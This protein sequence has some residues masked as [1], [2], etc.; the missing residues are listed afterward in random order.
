MYYTW[1][2]EIKSL[3][4]RT[5]TPFCYLFFLLNTSAPDIA[6]IPIRTRYNAIELL[7]LVSGTLSFA[8]EAGAFGFGIVFL[9]CCQFSLYF[10]IVT[11]LKLWN[12]VLNTLLA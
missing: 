7:S 10:K 3:D 5:D 9:V 6:V 2:G 1:E 8:S 4:I 11:F 12:H